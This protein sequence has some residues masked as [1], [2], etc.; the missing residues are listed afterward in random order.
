MKKLLILIGIF[1]FSYIT[2]FAQVSH[3][4][5]LPPELYDWGY[6]TIAEGGGSSVSVR[7]SLLNINSLKFQ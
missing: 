5:T 7:D 4:K 2:V 3:R 6:R 1:C